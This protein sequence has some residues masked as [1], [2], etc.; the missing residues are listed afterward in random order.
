M[1]ISQ[2]LMNWAFAQGWFARHLPSYEQ[3]ARDEI[4]VRP[5]GQARTVFYRQEQGQW[6]F[7]RHSEVPAELR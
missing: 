1:E 3:R 7:L 6:R 5:F 4:F 2:P